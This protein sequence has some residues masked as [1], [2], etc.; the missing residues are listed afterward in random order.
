[1]RFVKKENLNM[2]TCT[3]GLPVSERTLR[4]IGRHR[5]SKKEAPLRKKSVNSVR[6]KCIVV[7]LKLEMILVNIFL[8]LSPSL[9]PYMPSN[10]HSGS[11]SHPFQ[12]GQENV[13]SVPP[14]ITTFALALPGLA[15]EDL[16]RLAPAPKAQTVYNIIKSRLS[17]SSWNPNT[18]IPARFGIGRKATGRTAFL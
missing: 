4:V 15:A 11:I 7:C 18:P 13:S 17:T 12:V 1:M 10:L 8:L 5:H 3:P 6:D 14:T 2:M 9:L 16:V